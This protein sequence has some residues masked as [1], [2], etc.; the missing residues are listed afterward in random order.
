MR[1]IIAFVFMLL[2]AGCFY[3][4]E[5]N[6]ATRQDVVDAAERCGL[7]TFKPTDAPNGAYAAYVVDTIPDA[8]RK[9]D[10]IYD[11]LGRQGLLAT[12]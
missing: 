10:C 5:N 9:E 4:D 2:V 1:E 3:G 6:W 8:R 12:R 7:P 11:N